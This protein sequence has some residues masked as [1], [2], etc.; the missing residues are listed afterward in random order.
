MSHHSRA[1]IRLRAVGRGSGTALADLSCMLSAC[2]R[3]LSRCLSSLLPVLFS[4][5]SALI[6]RGVL[7]ECACEPVP[8]RGTGTGCSCGCAT[9]AQCRQVCRSC[10]HEQLCGVRIY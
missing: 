9:H 2:R 8:T 4:L 10:R 6:P 7:W 3:S 5:C 1:C